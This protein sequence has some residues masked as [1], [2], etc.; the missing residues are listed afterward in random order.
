MRP[1]TALLPLAATL[2]TPLADARDV[3]LERHGETAGDRLGTAVAACGDVDDDGAPDWIVGA[4]KANANGPNSGSA[5]VWSG[6]TGALLHRFDGASSGVEFGAAVAGAGDVNGDGHADLIVGAPRRSVGLLSNGE[7]LVL[8]GADGSVLHTITGH[9]QFGFTGSAVAG[10][11][12][13]DGDLHDDFLVATPYD[14]AGG[15]TDAGTVMLYSGA[16]GA[17][18][19]AHH[20]DTAG[21]H[22]GAAL[23]GG[24][25]VNG[26]GRGDYVIG[27]PEDWSNGTDAGIAR[28]YSGL[29]G[30]VLSFA[31]GATGE[32]T[33]A[34]VALVGDLDGNGRSEAAFGSPGYAGGD[35]RCEVRSDAGSFA[36]AVVGTGGEGLGSAIGAAGSPWGDARRCVAIG[37]P[38][39]AG[40]GRVLL[41]D[42]A[43]VA[44]PGPATPATAG[45]FG[46][47]LA[48]AFD[49]NGDGRDELVIGDPHDDAAA[50]DAGRAVLVSTVPLVGTPVCDGDAGACPCGNQGASDAGCTNSTGLGATLATIGSASVLQDD[51]RFV[52]TQAIANQPC[53]LFSANDLVN[54]SLG[55]PFRDGLLCANGGSD[56]HGVAFA[57]AGGNASWG[58]GLAATEG[59]TAG[60][61][62]VFQAWYR[63]PGGL[64]PCGS[65]SN[66]S[67]A[68]SVEFSD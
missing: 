66:T 38:Q 3:A 59:F 40:G 14:D 4:P 52:V 56:R 36:F 37:A 50:T 44:Q 13:V 25:D 23:H 31:L 67:L 11:G 26:D 42:Q 41:V 21:A 6:R 27:A 19:R 62:R 60:T 43:G 18:I 45:T 54:G 34:A 47:A 53:V 17:L 65:G 5:F 16:T 57:D 1:T 20:G 63:D 15:G 24:L 48:G 8:S 28:V 32:R 33:G 22:F 58:P 64:S 61:T 2:L 7:A 46:A 12:D 9:M 49:V 29:D 55:T 39:A 10:A 51:L 35:G 68:L 30:A